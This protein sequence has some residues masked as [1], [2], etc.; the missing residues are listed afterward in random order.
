MNSQPKRKFSVASLIWA[1]VV[2]ITVLLIA[3]AV[4]FVRHELRNRRGEL[5]ASSTFAF[6][7][8]YLADLETDR[9]LRTV[10]PYVAEQLTVF[11]KESDVRDALAKSL[12]PDR[13][14]LIR[15]E[16]YTQDAPVFAVCA[17]GREVLTLTLAKVEKGESA[18]PSYS[19]TSLVISDEID[20]GQK[21]VLEAPK[22][23][24]VTV[25]GISAEDFSTGQ[26]PY[27]ELSPFETAYADEYACERY[28]TGRLF[29]SPDVSAVLDTVR[30]RAS[31]VES[32]LIR[33]DYPLSR[34]SSVSLT[35]PKGSTVTVNGIPLSGQY[36]T[37]NRVRYPFLTRFEESL[38]DLPT[39]VVYQITGLFRTPDI[40]V[41]W[42]GV[43]LADGGNGRYRLPADLT[44]SITVCAPEYAVVKLNGVS[45]GLS[46]EIGVRFDLPILESVS[47]YVEENR[48]RMIRYTAT[49]LLATPTVTVTDER[50]RE[51]PLCP[52]HTSDG[53]LYYGIAETDAA[54]PDKEMLTSSTFAKN[55]IKY[56]Y[57]GNS[58]LSTRYN[59]CVDMT[60]AKTLAYQKIKDL[61]KKVYYYP[62]HKNITF[63]TVEELRYYDYGDQTYSVVLRI[64]FTTK[65]DGVSM[66]HEVEMEIL[67][68]YAGNIRRIIN[69]EVLKTTSSETK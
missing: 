24:I 45:L 1:I 64:P 29:L 36:Q 9:P 52:Y 55:Y 50:G 68:A 11:E 30:L 27:R 59:N 42:N 4:Y 14:T 40:T 20:L 6:A 66:T 5:L 31:T 48:P 35:V 57:S 8:A 19:V 58:K 56:V 46:E 26:I 28:E 34:M 62:K 69:Y 47:G 65:L 13:L 49:G 15:D 63:G 7:E 18:Y 44:Q 21:L 67:Y 60:P 3:G 37:E 10:W 41:E 17:D 16:D 22:G 51:L 23:A 39:S 33:Y 32:S 54:F 43:P 38:P 53:E 25:N 12:H 61:Y 2:P